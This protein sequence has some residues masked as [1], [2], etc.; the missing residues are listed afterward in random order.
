MT[1]KEIKYFNMAKAVSYTSDF[2]R[3]KIGAVL[4]INKDLIISSPNLKKSHPLQKSLN[5][6]RFNKEDTC[7]HYMHAEMKVILNSKC[8]DLSKAKLFVYR[9]NKNGNKA[10]CRPCKACMKM[11]KEANIK[12]VYYTSENGYCKEEIL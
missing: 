6:E 5:K 8:Y 9:E 10:M 12:E 11:I 4:V 3:I 1:N 7:N 2:K